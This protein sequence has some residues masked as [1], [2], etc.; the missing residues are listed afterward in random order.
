M[1]SVYGSSGEVEKDIFSRTSCRKIGA[2]TAKEK[3][4]F[5]KPTCSYFYIFQNQ[6]HAD[7]EFAANCVPSTICKDLAL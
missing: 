7:H 3:E 4:S 1:P 5:G 2:V 6:L